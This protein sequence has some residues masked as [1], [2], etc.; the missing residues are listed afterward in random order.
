MYATAKKNCSKTQLKKEAMDE[1]LFEKIEGY[2]QGTLP[3]AERKRF[4]A[5][6][7]EN[8]E[9]R[10]EVALQKKLVSSIETESV[11][12]LLEQIHE[13]NFERATPVVS[14]RHRRSYTFI[15][16]AA[17][18]ALLILS[19]WWYINSQV[20]QP[21]SLYAAYFSPAAGLPTTLS[22]TN[23]ARFSE[24]M[25]SYKLE[26]YAEAREWWQPLL[27]AD[28]ANDTLN[29]YMGVAALADE[30]TDGAINY[31]SKVVE[32]NN[33][34]YYTDAQWYLALACLLDDNKEK[35]KTILLDL[36][37]QDSTYRE[38]SIEIIKKIT[39]DG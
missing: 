33:S 34:I 25:I 13:E 16:A 32:D 36:S 38:Q 29:F 1:L 7:K 30:Q 6:M 24:G 14:I 12:Q 19:G 17:S 23:N 9:L 26:E 31:L 4:E 8:E 21:A 20:S 10:N 22:Y 37:E 3:L 35:A 39:S 2:L 5:E 15:A 11:R 27:Q 18:L 28:P